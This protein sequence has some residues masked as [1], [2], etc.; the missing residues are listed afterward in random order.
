MSDTPGTGEKECAAT[1]EADLEQH[2]MDSRIPKS[3]A[4]WWAKREIERL[5][6]TLNQALGIIVEFGD[7]NGFRNMSDAELG[8]AVISMPERIAEVLPPP[9]QGETA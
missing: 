2:I 8:K 4:E 6:S 9:Q 3:E 7:L 1:P 5:R